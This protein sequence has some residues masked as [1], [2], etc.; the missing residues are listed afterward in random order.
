MWMYVLIFSV[1][2]LKRYV[3]WN[4]RIALFF[5][6]VNSLQCHSTVENDKMIIA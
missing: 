5:F 1:K 2:S 6:S 3:V 4:I